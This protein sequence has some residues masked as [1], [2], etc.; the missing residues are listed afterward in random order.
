MRLP[1]K[2]NRPKKV[3]A[4]DDARTYVA[5][6]DRVWGNSITFSSITDTTVS[7]SGWLSRAPFP[8]VGDKLLIKMQSG[9][10][11]VYLFESVRRA[12][13]PNDMFTGS[14]ARAMEYHDAPRTKSCDEFIPN[15]SPFCR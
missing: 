15:L 5:H 3:K 8:R 4:L 6:G 11:E 9:M 14:A 1:W 2:R 10:W 12:C 7:V 13:D